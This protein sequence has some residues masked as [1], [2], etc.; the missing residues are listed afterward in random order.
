MKAIS[1]VPGHS[2]RGG[3]NRFSEK[4]EMPVRC[5]RADIELM[6]VGTGGGE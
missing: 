1:Q 4:V 5:Y 3:R 2:Q 6:Q